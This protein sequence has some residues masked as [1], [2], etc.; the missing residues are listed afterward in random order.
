MQKL[1]LIS[2]NIVF[3][4]AQMTIQSD[5]GN[6][7]SIVYEPT[8]NKIKLEA[9][10]NPGQY[11]SVGFGCTKMPNC[12]MIIWQGQGARGDT[13]DL[14]SPDYLAP[15]IDASQD[16]TGIRSFFDGF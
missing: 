14:W 4:A 12:D 13:L 6:A 15:R 7:F 5:L 1:I 11:F 8:L 16:F 10:V 9:V 3:A 2:V